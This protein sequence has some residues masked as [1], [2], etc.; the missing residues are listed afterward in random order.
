MTSEQLPDYSGYGKTEAT[1]TDLGLLSGLGMRLRDLE[2]Q[3]EDTETLLKN[4]QAQAREISWKQLPEL[5]D[6]L[7]MS[8]FMLKDGGEITVKEDLRVSLPSAPER[9]QEVI[10]WLNKNGAEAL[11]KRAFEIQFDKGDEAWAAKFERDCKQRKKPLNIER[12]ET[13]HTGTLKKF[14]T[15]KLEAGDE[16]PL[17]RLGAFRQ[18]IAKFKEKKK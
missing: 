6:S 11:I 17:D 5:M 13:I 7:N 15:D 14:L 2:K 8:K 3:I 9:R 1:G 16:V 10:D 4:L 12:L 18:T